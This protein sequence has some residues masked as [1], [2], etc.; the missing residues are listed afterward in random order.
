M[1]LVDLL[2]PAN[3]PEKTAALRSRLA[4]ESLEANNQLEDARNAWAECLADEAEGTGGSAATEKA[5]QA[6][7]L[8]KQVADK[9]AAAVRA[10]EARQHA[11][12]VNSERAALAARWA[13]AERLAE[14]RTKKAAGLKKT[15]ET[16]AADWLSLM[17]LTQE[18][19]DALPLKP[20]PDAGLLWGSHIESAVRM[21]LLRL[22]VDWAFPWPFGKVSLPEFMAPFED[23]QK[24]IQ[25]W[26]G[27]PRG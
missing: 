23:T 21:E 22:G 27:G 13:K 5:E 9:A 15:A 8:A 25:G 24:V 1:S 10:V 6:L 19:N 4:S 14:A 16:F 12:E 11:T 17:D 3:T 2:K 18:L 26:K 20:D 7:Q